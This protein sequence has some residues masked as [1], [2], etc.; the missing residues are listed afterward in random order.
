M[1][2]AVLERETL[3]TRIRVSLA[4]DGDGNFEVATGIPFFDHMLAQLA[5]HGGM[6]LEVVATG[7]IDVDLH[8]LV[9]DT[10]ILLGEAFA[11]AVGNKAG[12][13]RFSS[14]D[15]VLD[16]TLVKVALDLSGRA[17]LFYDVRF[18]N[19]LPLGAPGMDPQLAEEFFR[20]FV[21]A[22]RCTLHIESVRGKNT[23]HLLE[24]TF[25][26]FARAL[27]V[28]LRVTGDATVPTTKGLL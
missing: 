23:H 5:R 28:A 24:A 13:E 4:L 8:H 15:L 18:E 2:R 16:E 9:E 19:P 6:D 25:K 27:K 3:E 1:R 11:E 26:G 12:I 20:A 7:D 21:H 17:Y 14:V 22:A 10:G